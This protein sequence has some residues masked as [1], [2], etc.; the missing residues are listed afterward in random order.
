MSLEDSSNSPGQ[1]T[2]PFASG[3][4]LS[5]TRPATRL[6][7]S[8]IH[9]GK[10]AETLRKTQPDPQIHSDTLRRRHSQTLTYTWMHM[11]S[12][13]HSNRAHMESTDHLEAAR[14]TKEEIHPDTRRKLIQALGYTRRQSER[15]I[16]P[17]AQPRS[18]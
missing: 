13:R 9:T 5:H 10:D 18:T 15:D 11:E 14:H 8:I 12:Y 1:G 17:S 7:D 2:M 3:Q 16:K 6:K 4:R